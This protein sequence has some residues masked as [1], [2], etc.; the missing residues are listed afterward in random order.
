MFSCCLFQVFCKIFFFPLSNKCFYELIQPF[1]NTRMSSSLSSG[2]SLSSS[3]LR[4]CFMNGGYRVTAKIV[5]FRHH[6]TYWTCYTSLLLYKIIM[7]IRILKV[8]Q[9]KISFS[10]IMQNGGISWQPAILICRVPLIIVFIVFCYAKHLSLKAEI[11]WEK[12][13]K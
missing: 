3:F 13:L 4:L 11:L 6:I 10:L 8:L 5:A 1:S 12:V 9:D 2:I 7:K